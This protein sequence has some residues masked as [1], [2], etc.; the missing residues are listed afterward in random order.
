MA[1]LKKRHL[2]DLDL[3]RDRLR[4]LIKE[5]DDMY[6]AEIKGLEETPDQVRDR[7]IKRVAELKN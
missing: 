5:E 7:M 3:R 6:K 1:E 2:Q 4:A